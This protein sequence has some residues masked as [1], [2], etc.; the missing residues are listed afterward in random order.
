MSRDETYAALDR[1]VDWSDWVPFKDAIAAAPREPG[2]YLFRRP[3]THE[4]VYV[5]MAGERAGSSGG[6]QG[7]RGRLNIYRRGRGAVSGFGEAALDRALGDEE[8][9]ACQLDSLR[10]DGPKR[11]KV[12]AQ[13]AIQH[14]APEVRWTICS[15]AAAARALEK[16]IE[17]LLGSHRLWNRYATALATDEEQASDEPEPAYVFA[18]H[19]FT[20]DL[21]VLYRAMYEHSV[22]NADGQRSFNGNSKDVPAVKRLIHDMF[23][24]PVLDK[25]HPV[26]HAVR[27][28]VRDRLDTLGWATKDPGR[29]G[30][31]VLHRDV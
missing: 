29:S 4:V 31:Y 22:L 23:G 3:K 14:L 19:G 27:S 7:L 24:V 15:S 30:R 11:A 10:R 2:V 16:E 20:V 9:V 12:W 21:D 8:W 17:A 25:I 5:G 28:E 1:L 13:E 18:L 26:N 6:P